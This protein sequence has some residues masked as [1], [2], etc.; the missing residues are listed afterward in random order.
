M[1]S[2]DRNSFPTLL[3][4]FKEKGGLNHVTGLLLVL[5]LFGAFWV[6]AGIKT[7]FLRQLSKT[8]TTY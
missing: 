5:F 7:D 1:S 3:F 8:K 6:G 2:K 4:T